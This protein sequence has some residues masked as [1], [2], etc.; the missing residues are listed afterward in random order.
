MEAIINRG[1]RL[2]SNIRSTP[3]FLTNNGLPATRCLCCTDPRYWMF[4]SNENNARY[5]SALRSYFLFSHDH[6]LCQRM[7]KANVNKFGVTLAY[8]SNSPKQFKEDAYLPLPNKQLSVFQKMKQLTKDYWHI[9]IPVHILTSIGWVAIFY[10]LI[11]NGVDV[12]SMLEK[13]HLSEKY[14]EMIRNSGAGDWALTYALYKLFTPARYTV[15]IGGTTMSIRYLN[16]LG[17]LK[18]SS[19]KKA[20]KNVEQSQKSTTKHK[21]AFKTA[22][23]TEPPK[24]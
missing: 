14:L 1:L 24:T 11:K 20:A 9:L 5:R 16:R 23:Q 12:V 17:Y 6:F 21:T 8:S 10:T 2:V 18:A 13:M 3:S 22:R 19:F 15:T 7:L 4:G